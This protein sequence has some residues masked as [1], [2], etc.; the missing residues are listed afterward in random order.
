MLYLP[1]AWR[2]RDTRYVV[3]NLLRQA[4][5]IGEYLAAARAITRASLELMLCGPRWSALPR[6]IPLLPHPLGWQI[7][8]WV[9]H[10]L[11]EENDERRV[12]PVE[13]R[14]CACHVNLIASPWSA[15]VA[16]DAIEGALPHGSVEVC[17]IDSFVAMRLLWL[18]LDEDVPH[19]VALARLLTSYS[20][21]I[22]GEGQ[23]EINPAI[24]RSDVED[25]G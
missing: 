8:D 7:G 17:S 24:E 14:R 1:P 25:A 22:R 2:S 5:A 10:V 16:C 12:Q 15:S 6:R 18:C 23:L 13:L 4:D 19:P 9:F 3:N 20:R 21:I 11:A